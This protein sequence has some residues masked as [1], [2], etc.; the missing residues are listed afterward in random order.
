MLTPINKSVDSMARM[1]IINGKNCLL[2]KLYMLRNN[3][4]LVRLYPVT[5]SIAASD[6]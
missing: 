5:R 6:A 4:G 3:F 1:V 2:P